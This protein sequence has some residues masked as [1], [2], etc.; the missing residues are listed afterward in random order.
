M[1]EPLLPGASLATGPA[2][3]Q[4][5]QQ[6]PTGVAT[7]A[8]AG[9]V[10]VEAPVWRVETRLV[11]E[12]D[13]APVTSGLDWQP[14]TQEVDGTWQATLREVPAGGLYRLETRVQ[15]S[16]C[17][18]TR[19]LRGDYVHH[20]GVGDIWVIAGQSNASG[21]GLGYVDDPPELGLHQLGNDEVWKLATHPLEDAT[22]TRHPVTV[23]GVFQA[24]APWLA[25]ARAL[26]ESLGHPI[27]LVP[28][29]LG[30]SPLAMWEPARQGV[31]YTNL[32]QMVRLAGGRV[33]GVVWCQGESDALS[34]QT[35]TYLDRFAAFVAALRADLGEPELPLLSA[36]AARYRTPNAAQV[37]GA[38]SA[39]REVQ[40]QAERVVPGVVTIPTLDLPQSDEVHLSAVANVALGRRFAAAALHHVYRRPVPD[41]VIHLRRVA[42]VAAESPTLRL[43]FDLGPVGWRRAHLIRD[44]TVTAADGEVAVRSVTPDDRG[45]VDLILDRVPG[46]SA[47][48]HCGWGCDPACDLS[49]FDQRPLLAFS[50]PVPPRTG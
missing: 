44:F 47:S 49:D 18:D 35:G 13:G 7:I 8:L 19:P 45:H 28:T 46:E 20:L 31:L 32:L 34:G 5:L 12:S 15:R 6:D 27:G 30:G 24:H 41:P 42:W 4:I 16:G 33:R 48:V 21:T 11:R 25:F 3:W 29:A 23:H 43:E 10:R 36:Q 38:W 39:F 50:V 9:R 22:R 26:K 37:A 2:D 17:P 1:T 14:V 40:R